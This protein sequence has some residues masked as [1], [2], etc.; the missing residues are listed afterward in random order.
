MMIVSKSFNDFPIDV[1]DEIFA[2]CVPS[3]TFLPP[4]DPKLAPLLLMHVCSSW[5]KIALGVSR[6]WSSFAV[7]SPWFDLD[8]IINDELIFERRIRRFLAQSLEQIAL[9]QMAT[10]SSEVSLSLSLYDPPAI[11]PQSWRSVI[12]STVLVSAHA[13]R[14]L[15]LSF[16]P[17]ELVDVFSAFGAS[18]FNALESLDLGAGITRTT[19]FEILS[20]F[21]EAPKLRRLQS[22]YFPLEFQPSNVTHIS[23]TSPTS[24]ATFRS[25]LQGVP[26]L[27]RLSIVID[28]DIIS[29]P[30]MITAPNLTALSLTLKTFTGPKLFQS[31]YFPALDYLYFCC[32]S[33]LGHIYFNWQSGT[34]GMSQHLTSQLRQLQTLRLGYHD[35][36]SHVLLDVLHSTPDLVNLVVDSELVKYRA[37]LVGLTNVKDREPILPKL[38]H[39]T[40]FIDVA[41][42]DANERFKAETAGL[43]DALM[44]M[45]LSRTPRPT[46]KVLTHLSDAPLP[47][48]KVLLCHDGGNAFSDI[49]AAPL[50]ACQE[51]DHL[52]FEMR[53]DHSKRNWVI[54]EQW[55]W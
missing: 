2:Q 6:L 17:Y 51:L 23:L 50:K 31:L 26:R 25:I 41:S 7:A 36:E 20:S 33:D 29:S 10:K 30:I 45:I 12:E 42:A 54:E 48:R 14:R 49:V 40:T 13:I 27:E 24:S 38:Q 18:N 39:F 9:W 35:I 8:R 22:A 16:I 3:E 11:E 47:L 28:I 43:G 19:A 53:E 44:Q 32:S 46:A 5:R 15:K 37:F 52:S 21:L 34:L 1:I 55:F 4:L